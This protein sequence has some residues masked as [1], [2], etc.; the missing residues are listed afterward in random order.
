MERNILTMQGLHFQVFIN[1]NVKKKLRDVIVLCV[2]VRF[3]ILLFL[4][5]SLKYKM[6]KN[7]NRKAKHFCQYIFIP[8]FVK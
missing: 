2:L 4:K 3:Y 6:T 1:Y 8:C 5:I 7:I